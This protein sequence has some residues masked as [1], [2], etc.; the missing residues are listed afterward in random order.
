[1]RWDKWL[2]VRLLLSEGIGLQRIVVNG[3]TARNS[4]IWH[5]FASVCTAS[6]VTLVWH[7]YSGS[8]CQVE[9]E[10]AVFVCSKFAYCV[11][12]I[13]NTELVDA[14]SPVADNAIAPP[15]QD[16]SNAKSDTVA[17]NHAD[18][19]LKT[20]C[21]IQTTIV[22]MQRNTNKLTFDASPKGKVK[23]MMI[24]EWSFSAL[25][26]SWRFPCVPLFY[27]SERHSERGM[28]PKN[29]LTPKVRMTDAPPQSHWNNTAAHTF[30]V[31]HPDTVTN[32][33]YCL[34]G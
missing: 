22:A 13:N 16:I 23:V 15:D 5:A 34:V 31:Q 1:M 33:V 29:L 2:D 24:K 19:V 9:L 11:H 17:D 12:Y 7:C 32:C 6:S 30:K 28:V 26:P 8:V 3:A 27:Y 14:P 18:T 25:D 21:S 20:P 10:Q 4:C